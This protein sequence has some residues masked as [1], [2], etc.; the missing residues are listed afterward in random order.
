MST[1]RAFEGMRMTPLMLDIEMEL[2]DIEIAW[3]RG[4]SKTTKSMERYAYL[5]KR[6]VELYAEHNK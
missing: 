4:Q 5:S 3:E 2:R 6:L 1:K